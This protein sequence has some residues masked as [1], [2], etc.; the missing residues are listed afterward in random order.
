MAESRLVIEIEGDRTPPPSAAPAAPT[1][2]PAGGA[3]PSSARP[4]GTAFAA[5]PM[6]AGVA[7]PA[8]PQAP[9]GAPAP[10]TAKPAGTPLPPMPG[11]DAARTAIDERKAERDIAKAE[12]EARRERAA[13]AKRQTEEFKKQQRE[14]A[15]AMKK[16]A[17]DDRAWANAR[18]RAPAAVAKQAEQED[19]L[20]QIRTSRENRE[21]G[22]SRTAQRAATISRWA[23]RAGSFAQWGGQAAAGAARGGVAAAGMGAAEG[24]MAGLSRLGP[25]GMAAAAGLQALT[26][27]A[28]AASDAV[29]AF[30]DRGREL[31]GYNG[32]LAGATATA[33]LRAMQQDIREA[34][35]NGEAFAGII[36]AQSKLETTMREL[37]MPIQKY[38]METL[39]ALMNRILEVGLGVLEALNALLSKFS[40]E[41]TKVKELIGRIKG[42]MESREIVNP[43]ADLLGAADRFIAPP[44]VAP[45]KVEGGGKLGMPIL[46]TFKAKK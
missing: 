34:E 42:I 3:L 40:L 13:E 31:A 25:Y 14:Q 39:T 8:T 2:A 9:A 6:P 10:V 44:A 46:D 16:Q 11:A 19:Q 21:M 32:Q 15:D 41:S 33:D 36:D 29:K 7:S 12:M 35:Q 23:G 28:T 30:A 45:R 1:P 22:E 37:L 27:G 26:K 38:M 20:K 17:E 4:A 5:P 43:I 18:M 24:A